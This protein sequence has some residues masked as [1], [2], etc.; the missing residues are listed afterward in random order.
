[1]RKGEEK[2]LQTMERKSINKGG[3]ATAGTRV[4]EAEYQRQNL[5]KHGVLV[6]RCQHEET[7]LSKRTTRNPEG[8]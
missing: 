2:A 3:E 5:G 8:F 7:G 4:S 1:M 6:P